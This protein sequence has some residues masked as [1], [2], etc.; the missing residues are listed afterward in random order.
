[1]I[2]TSHVFRSPLPDVSIPDIPIT[3]FVMQ[4]CQIL[5]DKPAIINGPTGATLT[6]AQLRTRTRQLAGGLQAN[7]FK[8]GSV[9]AL[10]APNCPDY[11]VVFHAAAL[12]AGT[13]TTVNPTYGAEEIKQ[14]LADSGA[15]FAISDAACTAQVAELSLI[16]I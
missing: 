14:Q 4:K 13:V 3:E 12:C 10:I 9:L 5:G 1:M 7:G 6:F 11:A 16:H 15:L 2:M 8:P